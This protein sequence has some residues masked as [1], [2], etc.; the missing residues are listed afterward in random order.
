MTAF[1]G[2]QQGR[3]IGPVWIGIHDALGEQRIIIDINGVR[4]LTVDQARR[5]GEAALALA[6]ELQAPG[7]LT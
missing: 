3:Y 2:L 6:D 1:Q 4:E 7:L 5:L